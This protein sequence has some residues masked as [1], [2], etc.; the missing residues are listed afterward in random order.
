MTILTRSI[1]TCLARKSQISSARL[2]TATLAHPNAPLDIHP[3]VQ[4]ALATNKPV[5][6]LETTL[7]THGFPYPTNYSLA[8]DLEKIVRSTGSVPATIGIIGG[9]VKI[10]LERSELEWL[11]DRA[12]NPSVV[13]VSRRDIA[14][15]IGAQ[16]DGG[17]TCSATLIFAA[18]AGIKVFA[19][20]GLGGV[21]RGGQDSMDISADLFELTRC[22]VGLV[23]SGIKSILDI[24]RTLEYLETLG[25]PVVTYG[26]TRDFPSFFT[27]LSGFQVGKFL[28]TSLREAYLIIQ[29]PWNVDS[30]STAAKLLHT[31]WQLD[32]DNGI[33]IAAPIPEEH[34]KIGSSI[35]QAVDQAVRESEENGMSKRGK[36]VTPWLLSRIV[37]LTR[38]ESLNSN[39]A[40]LK[41]TALIGG[42][43]AVEYQ[44]I[45]SEP[46]TPTSTPGDKPQKVSSR[47]EDSFVPARLAVV[48]S[49]AID[50]TAQASKGSDPN[51]ATHS[52]VPG[53]VEMT[54]GG[55]ARNIAEA[56]HRVTRD[57]NSTL[58]LS[59]VGNDAF[60]RLLEDETKTIGMRSDGLVKSKL[61][62]SVCNMFVDAEGHL[63]T[64][65]AD[66][67][68]T[69]AFEGTAVLEHLQKHKPAIVAFD[70]NLSHATIQSVANFCY[71][72][73]IKTFFEP[74]SITKST[75][76][77]QSIQGL[78]STMDP[79]V[80]PIT[81][82]SPNLL[83]LAQIYRVARE[84]PYDL[85][86][87]PMWWKIADNMALGQQYRTDLERLARKAVST[88]DP[89]K[90]T[91]SFMVEK[92]I[93][94]MAVNLLPF[95]QH[96]II[97][98]GELGV[99]VAMR[100]SAT[101]SSKASA[102]KQ[103]HDRG[104]RCIV[105]QG[106]PGE[107]VVMKH[108]PPLPVDDIM[109]VT[110]AG[111][112]FVGSVLAHLL[113]KPLSVDEPKLLEAIIDT[114]QQA[115]VLT[116][117]S[118]RAVSPALSDLQI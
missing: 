5:V 114:A 23:S 9:R 70:G 25:V 10:G 22:P 18:L 103:E 68:I 105:A 96:L 19:T 110:G 116:L 111:D 8:S 92:G 73:G 13:K 32:M 82:A 90:G 60:G 77:L 47:H 89:S 11:A 99:V 7:V 62:T 38:G 44:K 109:N 33:L 39:V 66:M 117:K 54:L 67:G 87:H 43:I 58:L 26:K 27:R 29:V 56:S 45:L 91:L 57:S 84:E 53:S 20:G 81:F 69:E 49:S 98:C 63:L 2:S 65:V 55:V 30:P 113:R 48:G 61:K 46:T 51:L 1:S 88:V 4:E 36:E 34:E 75:S 40:L 16:M 107:M 94:S 24:G 80:A 115:A 86:S 76:I 106:K 14:P 71:S 74:T 41:N 112:S 83:E 93:A 79:T 78:V 118:Q 50:I 3:E 100:L 52:T 64:G 108:F 95:I 35:Q 12:N 31:Q 59:P 6:A 42:Q 15:T 37:K 85:M 104:D 21:H 72:Q 17:T 97:K 28:L 102:W 101:D